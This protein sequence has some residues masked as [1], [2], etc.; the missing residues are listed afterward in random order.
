MYAHM[1]Q[2]L[3]LASFRRTDTHN[4]G[5]GG[6]SPP[7]AISKRGTVGALKK[8]TPLVKAG[9]SKNETHRI[10]VE[11]DKVCLSNKINHNKRISNRDLSW[12]AT[13]STF[14]SIFT[15]RGALC[16]SLSRRAK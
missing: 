4:V 14:L 10:S 2:E 16:C 13:I 9:S 5:V 7:V 11:A 3:F 12:I 1:Y 8:K 6:S 15:F